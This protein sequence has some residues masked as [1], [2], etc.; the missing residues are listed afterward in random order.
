MAAHNLPPSVSTGQLHP[1]FAR[2]FREFTQVQSSV[3]RF[4]APIYCQNE[5]PEYGGERCA[6]VAVVSDLETE[7]ALCM[8]C[9][10]G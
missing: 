4:N 7:Q 2:I 9:F 8:G 10:R 1:V 3:R 6:R 5:L